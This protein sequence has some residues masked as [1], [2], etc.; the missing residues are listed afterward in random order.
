[1]FR[2]SPR[3]V[4]AEVAAERE[5]QVDALDEALGLHAQERD[6]RGIQ[7]E[8][9]LLHAAQ[10]AGSDAKADVR[11]LDRAR[12]LADRTREDLL[13]LREREA[14][15]QRVSTSLNARAPTRAVLG[16][17]RCCSAVRTSTCA[18]SRPPRKIGAAGWR[19]S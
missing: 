17:R 14:R 2:S 19:Q 16:D 7:R 15:R 3:H 13:A 18:C 5:M 6:L 1:M 8:L 12:V 4:R 9:L 10:V 11:E